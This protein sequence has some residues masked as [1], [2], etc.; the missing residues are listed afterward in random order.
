MSVG[1]LADRMPGR[2]SNFVRRCLYRLFV[3]VGQTTASVRLEKIGSDYGGWSVPV[4]CISQDWI[5]YCGGVGED[6]TF[7]LGMID[8]F[9]CSVWAFDPTPRAIRHV[10]DVAA[11]QPHFH[12]QPVGLWSH[13]AT[14]RFYAPQNPDFVSHSALNLQQT[15]TFFEADCVSVRE[16][17]AA[18]GHDRIHLLKLDIEGAEHATLQAMLS[19]RIHPDVICLEIDQPAPIF[20]TA[21]TMWRLSRAGYRLVDSEGWNF[22]LFHRR[23]A[24]SLQPGAA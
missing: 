12:F 2:F 15:S 20:A 24:V 14:L 16:A 8:R 23:F 6:I 4:D 3:A 22:T 18:H 5:C 11:A 21:A 10:E 17:M 9:G 1:T 13:A 7:D 19:D